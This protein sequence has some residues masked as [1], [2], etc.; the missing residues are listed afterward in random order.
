[1]ALFD[2]EYAVNRYGE[3]MRAEGRLEGRVEGEAIGVLKQAKE[4]ALQMKKDGF[5][6]DTIARIHKVSPQ[7]VHQWLAE[8]SAELLN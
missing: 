5:P 7:T 4:T 8:V 3:E 1:M 6:E 2:Q